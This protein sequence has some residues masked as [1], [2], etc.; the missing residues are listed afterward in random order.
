MFPGFETVSLSVQRLSL[1]PESERADVLKAEAEAEVKKAEVE[2]EKEKTK[3]A[4]LATNPRTPQKSHEASAMGA[5]L[6]SVTLAHFSPLA[7]ASSPMTEGAEVTPLQ[8]LQAGVKKAL[9][10]GKVFVQGES[11]ADPN[12]AANRV[13]SQRYDSLETCWSALFSSSVLE[14]LSEEEASAAAAI[15]ALLVSLT[16]TLEGSVASVSSKHVLFVCFCQIKCK[17]VSTNI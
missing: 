10:Y 12:E 16:C 7:A 17:R 8:K 4:Q 13:K 11:V 3:R 6:L 9:T 15:S 2:I 5:F 14:A 1:I